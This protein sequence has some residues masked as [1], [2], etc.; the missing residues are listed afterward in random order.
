MHS[1]AK[2]NQ[3]N[4]GRQLISELS[5]LLMQW[6][7]STGLCI[8]IRE[9][10]HSYI[11]PSCDEGTHDLHAEDVFVLDRHETVVCRPSSPKYYLGECCNLFLSLF[12]LRSAEACIYT[13]SKEAAQISMMFGNEFRM[14]NMQTSKSGALKDGRSMQ[15]NSYIVVPIVEYMP[16]NLEETME[17][18]IARLVQCREAQAIIFRGR[19]I[20][21]WEDSW[22]RAKSAMEY[23]HYLFQLAIQMQTLQVPSSGTAPRN[24]T[25]GYMGGMQVSRSSYI[26]LT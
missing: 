8:A 23:V 5:R 6:K 15:Q 25:V 19:G 24:S 3:H 10:D 17:S 22:L 13:T 12:R 26:R 16:D 1:N 9:S 18:A 4:H 7:T 14:P 11:A 21:V 2:P 20:C